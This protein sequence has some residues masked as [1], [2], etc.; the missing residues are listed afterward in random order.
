MIKMIKM[1]KMIMIKMIMMKQKLRYNHIL[2][3]TTKLILTYRLKL[4]Y[5][6]FYNIIF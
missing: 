1:I 3:K 2:L 4:L 5:C 6:Q